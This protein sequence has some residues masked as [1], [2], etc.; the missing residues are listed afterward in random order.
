MKF[1]I[2][3]VS[4]IINNARMTECNKQQDIKKK[5]ESPDTVGVE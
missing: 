5:K 4:F 1:N 3:S 2:F